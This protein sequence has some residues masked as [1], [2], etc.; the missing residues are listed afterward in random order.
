M[1]ISCTE[2]RRSKLISPLSTFGSSIYCSTIMTSWNSR[3]LKFRI[4]RVWRRRYGNHGLDQS[5]SVEGISWYRLF[6]DGNERQRVWS[7]SFDRQ[8]MESG[9][10]CSADS[11]H[12]NDIVRWWYYFYEGECACCVV[13]SSNAN[14]IL[15]LYLLNIWTRSP[16]A[17]SCCTVIFETDRRRM[18]YALR[19]VVI[20]P[21]NLNNLEN[22]FEIKVRG[23]IKESRKGAKIFRREMDLIEKRRRGEYLDKPVQRTVL[24]NRTLLVKFIRKKN[25]AHKNKIKTRN[26]I[27][28]ILRL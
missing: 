9:E 15:T 24:F 27:S 20:I 28:Y 23:E 5:H 8:S 18:E 26:V 14:V 25:Y 10:R 17:L 19:W 3:R 12:Q 21:F 2:W 22:V 11:S 6:E 7:R 13:V 1:V 16:R 4:S